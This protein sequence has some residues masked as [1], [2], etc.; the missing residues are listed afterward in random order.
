MSIY[1]AREFL[2]R[3]ATDNTIAGKAQGLS[4]SELASLAQ[5]IG[6]S[7]TVGDLEKAMAGTADPDEMRDPDIESVSGGM[8]RSKF[9]YGGN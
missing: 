6:Y 4:V 3:I 1:V 2:A 5:G 8:A 9:P 7:V